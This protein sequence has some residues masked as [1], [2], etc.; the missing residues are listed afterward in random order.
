MDSET[1]PAPTSGVPLFAMT[2]RVAVPPGLAGRGWE[3]GLEEIGSRMNLEIR[4]SSPEIP[5]P[6]TWR[7]P[8]R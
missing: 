3:A 4:V 8:T 6:R 1:T 5:Q 2:A 7:A